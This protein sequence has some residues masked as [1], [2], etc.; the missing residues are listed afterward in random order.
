MTPRNTA[1]RTGSCHVIWNTVE[2]VFN[3]TNTQY[4]LSSY[5]VVAVTQI[6]ALT[7]I[8]SQLFQSSGCQNWLSEILEIQ[9]ALS[10]NRLDNTR[11]SET[12]MHGQCGNIWLSDKNVIS[13]AIFL[14]MNFIQFRLY[15]L[16]I[17]E[18]TVSITFQSLICIQFEGVFFFY[19]SATVYNIWVALAK[20]NHSPATYVLCLTFVAV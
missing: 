16:C 18:F 5:T 20:L 17:I 12:W 7:K 10:R 8:S 11:P 3:P 4:L 2:L 15:K 1:G 13:G 9:N 6:D 19:A 14:H